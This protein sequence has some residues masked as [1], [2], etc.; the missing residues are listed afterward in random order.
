MSEYRVFDK[1]R[2][3]LSQR[4]YVAAARRKA[5]FYSDKM[6]RNSHISHYRQQAEFF[7]GESALYER[8]IRAIYGVDGDAN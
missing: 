4:R 7:T 5:K 6:T 2:Y 3:A 1:Y 8:K